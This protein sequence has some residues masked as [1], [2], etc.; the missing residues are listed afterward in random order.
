M[1]SLVS[2]KK[3][4]DY[5]NCYLAIKEALSEIGFLSLLKDKKVF[6]KV[7]L[8][9]AYHPE[10]AVNTHP[11]FIRG[12]I[13]VVKE[14]GGEAIIGESS[15]T[16]GFTNEAFDVS[17]ISRVARETDTKIVNLDAS[18]IIK[19]RVNGKILKEI[20][21]PEDVLTADIKV[22]LPKLKTHDFM[23]LSGAIK[24]QIGVL[25]G[26]YKCKVH[27]IAPSPLRLAELLS[28]LNLYL[29]FDLAVVDAILSMEG[30]GPVFGKPRK[31]SF[32]C[33]GQDLVAVDTVCSMMMGI[34]PED[35]LTNK[36]C[37][38]RGLGTANLNDINLICGNIDDNKIK[39]DIPRPPSKFAN[40][41][42]R[43]KYFLKSIAVVPV[44]VKRLCTGCGICQ[45]GC[46]ARAI[47]IQGVSKRNKDC[48]RC[49]RCYNH[50]PSQAIK[51]KCRWYLKYFFKKSARRMA[52]RDLL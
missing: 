44:T 40:I 29:R 50:C 42:Y 43:L 27:S 37:E 35:V 3:G 41:L 6:L 13:R 1:S 31:S 10:E 19:C 21:L 2:V 16:F 4:V 39:F 33:A 26:S 25:P 9:T 48:I 30:K 15:G 8:V 12:V 32:I 18:K 23:T 36:I 45:Q 49:Y 24:N 17:G 20:Y 34:K 5:S 28:E 46:P 52:L 11:E 22:T 38:R 7:S 47:V 51:L 14:S